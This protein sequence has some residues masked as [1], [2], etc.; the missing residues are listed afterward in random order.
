M[1]WAGAKGNKEFT[2]KSSTLCE[3]INDIINGK[4]PNFQ[5][6]MSV[7]F[8]NFHKDVGKEATRVIRVGRGATHRRSDAQLEPFSTEPNGRD[9]FLEGDVYEEPQS[10]DPVVDS[11]EFSLC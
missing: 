9:D 4:F 7:H 6:N 5:K 10:V 1:S 8:N 11:D 2:L 3:S